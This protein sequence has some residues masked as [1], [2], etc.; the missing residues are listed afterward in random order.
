MACIDDTIGGS[1]ALGRTCLL[2]LGV[3]VS[4]EILGC[5]HLTFLEVAHG[6][7]RGCLLGAL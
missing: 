4:N 7:V 6:R 1:T 3:Q 2:P 5:R